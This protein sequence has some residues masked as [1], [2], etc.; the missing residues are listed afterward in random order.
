M[1]NVVEPFFEFTAQCIQHLQGA[2]KA[3]NIK[4]EVPVEAASK[5]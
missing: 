1:A 2:S 5:G 4:I 3:D